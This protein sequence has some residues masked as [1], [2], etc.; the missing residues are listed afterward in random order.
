MLLT[1]ID[2]LC[3][4]KIVGNF[5]YEECHAAVITL[6]NHTSDNIRITIE[7]YVVL[8]FRADAAQV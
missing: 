1:L 6:D 2:N 4:H 8:A 3:L 7:G 5:L